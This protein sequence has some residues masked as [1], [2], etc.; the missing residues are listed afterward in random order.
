MISSKP[1][2]APFAKYSKIQ[3]DFDNLAFPVKEKV[4]AEAKFRKTLN[5]NES[6]NI[7]VP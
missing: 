7:L 3:K 1:M 4:K 5:Y 6:T 2:H